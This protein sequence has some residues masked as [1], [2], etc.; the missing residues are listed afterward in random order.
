MRTGHSAV[1]HLVS[2][3]C[4]SIAGFVAT[5][6]IARELG[7]EALGLYTIGVALLFVSKVPLNAVGRAISKR[8]SEGSNEAVFLWAGIC[9]NTFVGL[10]LAG[11]II[12]FRDPVNA[13][14]GVDV[15]LLLAC[16][17]LVQ[18]V[19]TAVKSGIVGQKQVWQ[20]GIIELV[21][22]VGRTTLQIAF[23]LVGFHVIGLYLGHVASLTFAVVVAL[24]ALRARLVVPTSESIRSLFSFSKYSWLGAVKNRSFGWMDTL[25]LAFFVSPSLVGVYEVA[26]TLSNVLALAGGSIQETLFPELSDLKTKGQ[27]DA[28]RQI[29]RA[30][31]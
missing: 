4:V 15:A 3:V 28:I 26:W 17:V 24:I 30:H 31:V 27:L 10:L 22:R 2:R 9:I 12:L 19:L 6:F 5:F 25:V 1:V 11:G 8:V 13:Y 14:V 23:V 16:L 21:E 20:A 29:G 7:S 18:A